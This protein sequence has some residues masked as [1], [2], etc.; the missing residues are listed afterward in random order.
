MKP[1]SMRPMAVV[2]S[3]VPEWAV[4]L[5]A[6]DEHVAEIR[7]EHKAAHDAQREAVSHAIRCGELLLL[8]REDVP[9]GQWELWVQAKCKFSSRAARGYL[10]LARLDAANRQ[11]VAEMSLRNAL[12]EIASE[13]AR[14]QRLERQAARAAHREAEISAQRPAAGGVIDVEIICESRATSATI[15]TAVDVEKI[16]DRATQALARWFDE[17]SPADRGRLAAAL[18]QVIAER[19]P[20]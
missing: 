3:A 18:R 5:P 1:A 6:D 7:R 10:R 16:I 14:Q 13:S 11:R 19:V 20:T 8:A 17:V 9:H 15:G 2:P 12:A 4:D